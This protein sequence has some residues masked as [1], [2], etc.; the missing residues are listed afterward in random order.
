MRFPGLQ[1]SACCVLKEFTCF[2]DFIIGSLCLYHRVSVT[3]IAEVIGGKISV[4]N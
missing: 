3:R 1:E 4:T 2:A